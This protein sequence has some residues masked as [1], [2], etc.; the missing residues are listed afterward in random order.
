[1]GHFARDCPKPGECL[2]FSPPTHLPKLY[3]TAGEEICRNCDSDQHISKDCPKPRDYSRVT[4]RTCGQK[5]HTSVKCKE[6]PKDDT[7]NA[8][9]GAAETFGDAAGENDMNGFNDGGI[10]V[11]G[12]QT[13]NDSGPVVAADSGW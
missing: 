4:C 13:A 11:G 12:W 7:D 8:G 2:S 3:L 9:F 10:A 5:G 1:M 6:P